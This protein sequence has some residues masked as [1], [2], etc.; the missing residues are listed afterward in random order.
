MVAMPDREDREGM[1]PV[2]PPEPMEP[3]GS[4]QGSESTDAMEFMEV[5]MRT[6]A[7]VNQKGGSGKTTAAVNLAAALAELG[8]RVLLL[9]LDPQGTATRWLGY[10]SLSG[11]GLSTVLASGQGLEQ[12]ATPTDEPRVDLVPSD[13]WL[14]IAERRDF[15]GTAVPQLALARALHGAQLDY[16]TLLID[17]PGR[18]SLL[19]VAALAA[20][21]EALSP[22]PAGA[23]ELEHLRELDE[24]IE[25]VRELNATLADANLIPWAVDRRTVLARDVSERLAAWHSGRLM[26]ATVRKSVRAAEAFA[27]RQALTTFAPDHPITHDIRGLAAVFAKEATRV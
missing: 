1:H 22:I 25:A 6:V 4:R 2:E 10:D 9:D 20:A 17:T 16:S 26:P 12:L 23:M 21:D 3:M 27:H 5:S 7:I 24:T 13:D 11:S 19:T 14:E 15:D 8:E 18:L